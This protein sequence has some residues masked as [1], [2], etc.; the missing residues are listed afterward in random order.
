MGELSDEELRPLDLLG[1]NT[2]FGFTGIEASDGQRLTMTDGTFDS[3]A[4]TR[5]YFDWKVQQSFKVLKQGD[6]TDRNGNVTGARAEVVLESGNLGQT[7]SA[8]FWTAGTTFRSI[9]SW[10][11]ADA[12]ELEEQ[13]K[14]GVT[15]KAP[16]PRP[17]FAN[18]AILDQGRRITSPD[19]E[20][21]VLL[22]GLDKN[23]D[24]FPTAVNVKVGGKTLKGFIRFGLNAEVLWSPDSKAFAI[25]GSSEGGNGAY[26]TDVFLLAPEKLVTVP[27]TETIWKE[28]GHPVK[29][30]WPEVPNVVAVTWVKDSHVLLVAAQIIMHSNCDSYGTFKA[31]EVSLPAGTIGRSYDQL[32]TKEKF[33]AQLGDWLASAPDKCIRSPKS[34]YV[35]A[36]HPEPQQ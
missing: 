6:Q 28:F 31:Y 29:C 13:L 18:D 12:L 35:P 10:S 25:T 32:E 15:F 1:L 7:M 11:L 14:N 33:G 8:V 2:D 21:S 9:I 34:C 22:V 23:A 26:L 16:V 20:K 3:L 19:G 4:D 30:G 17:L 24:D 27:L 36:N 5:R